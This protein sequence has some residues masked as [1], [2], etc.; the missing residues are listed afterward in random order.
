M[1]FD[2]QVTVIVYDIYDDILVLSVSGYLRQASS[3]LPL[4]TH[5]LSISIPVLWGDPELI[6]VFSVASIAKVFD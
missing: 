4:P 1:R 6:L 2:N 5:H 3:P